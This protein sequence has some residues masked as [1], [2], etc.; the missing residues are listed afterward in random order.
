MSNVSPWI[1]TW[2]ADGS[3]YL[4]SGQHRE[5]FG[6]A[7]Q[8]VS[9]RCRAPLAHAADELADA[10]GTAWNVAPVAGR[11]VR[12]S[13]SPPRTKFQDEDAKAALWQIGGYHGAADAEAGEP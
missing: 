12:A 7:L 3:S 2:P 11:L 13:R 9:R 1:A 5:Q 6:G 10:Q 4:P 8:K